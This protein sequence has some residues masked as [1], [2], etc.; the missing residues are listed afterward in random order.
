MHREIREYCVE[1]V[2]GRFGPIYFLHGTPTSTASAEPTPSQDRRPGLLAAWATVLA[3]L[4]VIAGTVGLY[5][6]L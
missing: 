5:S 1:V 3:P 4:L 6:L 2:P